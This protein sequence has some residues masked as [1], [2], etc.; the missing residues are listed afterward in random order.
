MVRLIADLCGIEKLGRNPALC[1]VLTGVFD[2]DLLPTCC[3]D[4]VGIKIHYLL[5][6]CRH[7]N[8]L[9]I[10]HLFCNILYNLIELEI[11]LGFIA[12]PV[13]V[14]RSGCQ[15]VSL[16]FPANCYESPPVFLSFWNAVSC[17]PLIFFK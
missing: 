8:I 4:G 1:F 16:T 7:D 6:R 13:C 5:W 2:S 17:A 14:G 9:C 12:C 15:F 11:L 3:V 10:L